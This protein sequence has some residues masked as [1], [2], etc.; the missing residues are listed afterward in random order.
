MPHRSPARWLAPIAL[1]A[2]VLAVF[3]VARPSTEEDSGSSSSGAPAAQQTSTSARTT[4]T[5]RRS[6]PRTYTVQAGDVLSAIAEKTGVSLERLQELN[7]D[8]DANALRTGQK[9]KLAP[10]SQ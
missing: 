9:L 10:S 8:V 7:P 3:L 5:R 2:A 4:T 1:L 6:A